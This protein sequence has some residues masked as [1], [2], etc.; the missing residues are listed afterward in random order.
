MVVTSAYLWRESRDVNL[1]RRDESV[2]IVVKHSEDV[3]E[4]LLFGAL[5]DFVCASDNF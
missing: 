3:L 5:H 4:L 2:A 1:L